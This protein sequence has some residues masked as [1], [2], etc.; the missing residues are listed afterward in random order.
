[1]RRFR[2]KLEKFLEFRA[3]HERR[4]ELLLAER[5]GRCVLLEA[6]LLEIASAR[7]RSSREMFRAG[8]GLEDYRAAELYIRR[9]DIERDKLV[10]ELAAAEIAREEAR[11]DYVEKRRSREAIDKLKE[12]R[13]EDYYKLAEREEIKALD[14][15]ARRAVGLRE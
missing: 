2:F 5:A 6:R 13:R 14:D 1:M 7:A 12:R 10:I 3:L 9:L 11:Q 4:A 15:I 8:R